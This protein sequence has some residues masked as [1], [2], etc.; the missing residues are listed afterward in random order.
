M[1]Y[2]YT[3]EYYSAIKKNKIVPLAATWV[4]LELLILSELSQWL[5]DIT[6]RWNLKCGTHEPIYITES[7]SQTWR[8]DLWLPRGRGRKWDG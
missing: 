8:K 2:I 4:Q 5:Y 3:M 1:W 6:Y 7:D